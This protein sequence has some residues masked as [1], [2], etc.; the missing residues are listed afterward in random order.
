MRESLDIE[1]AEFLLYL[2]SK[3]IQPNP[4]LLNQVRSFTSFNKPG[5]HK[6][7]NTSSKRYEYAEVQRFTDPSPPPSPR[8][9]PSPRAK[10]TSPPASPSMPSAS[11]PSAPLP[12]RVFPVVE[13]E[14]VVVETAIET[15][16]G[17][18]QAKARGVVL[19]AD[20]EM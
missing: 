18:A 11:A 14:A 15:T 10:P 17:H 3:N 13:V 5:F 9:T 19:A 2:E 6:S 20:T 8:K 1:P 12:R 7:Y 4:E 16:I